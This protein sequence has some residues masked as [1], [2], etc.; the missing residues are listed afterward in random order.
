MDSI[1]RNG[2]DYYQLSRLLCSDFPREYILKA[3]ILVL[4]NHDPATVMYALLG[5]KKFTLALYL[6]VVYT[7]HLE[8]LQ[9]YF[10]QEEQLDFLETYKIL[11]AEDTKNQKEFSKPPLRLLIQGLLNVMKRKGLFSSLSSSVVFL[12][13]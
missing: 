3:V 9:G 5:S 7:E 4:P 2:L 6:Y 12:T 1:S 11:V 13:E 8:A 10:Q